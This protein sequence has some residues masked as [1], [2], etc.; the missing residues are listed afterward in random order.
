[1][2]VVNLLQNIGTFVLYRV[3]IHV[4]RV[5]D[6]YPV[7]TASDKDDE[8]T[9]RYFRYDPTWQWLCEFYYGS[10]IGLV[11]IPLF[12]YKC[13]LL[14]IM[15]ITLFAFRN[16]HYVQYYIFIVFEWLLIFYIFD[17]PFFSLAGYFDPRLNDAEWDFWD[18]G[19][20]MFATVFIISS[21]FKT[22]SIDSEFMNMATYSIGFFMLMAVALVYIVVGICF[23]IVNFERFLYDSG[24][25]AY[26]KASKSIWFQFLTMMRVLNRYNDMA[27][28][29][30]NYI[31]TPFNLM[32]IL[33]IPVLLIY[34]TITQDAET[35]L[36][37]RIQ[38]LSQGVV[39]LTFI[40]VS[41]MAYIARDTLTTETF[42]I[43]F[44]VM[45]VTCIL[46]GMVRAYM[47]H[48]RSMQ[49]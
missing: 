5:L 48:S 31:L 26:D 2:S 9:Y 14:H 46:L 22:L 19:V 10:H 7:R 34:V 16:R 29:I 27:A 37:E 35:V 23:G 41:V 11:G 45:V 13:V 38:G 17:L 15:L 47:F 3:I 1:M 20:M 12:I 4:M 36:Y 40:C 6:F 32:I 42:W 49:E 30:T 44:I 25:K 18:Y 21:S 33:A 24:A 39:S 28:L 43:S 8:M